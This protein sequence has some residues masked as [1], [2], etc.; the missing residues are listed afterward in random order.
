[1]CFSFSELNTPVAPM[2][3]H[4]STAT[5]SLRLPVTELP[6]SNFA[7]AIPLKQGE[8]RGFAKLRLS[9]KKIKGIYGDWIDDD[10]EDKQDN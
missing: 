5:N 4:G 6:P 8:G 2:E 1:M 7:T 9:N 10:E 3:V